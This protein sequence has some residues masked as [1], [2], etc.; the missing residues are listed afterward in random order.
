M[1]FGPILCGKER[2]PKISA[3]ACSPS[4]PASLLMLLIDEGFEKALNFVI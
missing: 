3:N 4:L 1:L 2:L